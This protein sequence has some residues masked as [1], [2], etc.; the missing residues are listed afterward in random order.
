MNTFQHAHIHTH[1]IFFSPNPNQHQLHQYGGE[2]VAMPT[3]KVFGAAAEP[4]RRAPLGNVGNLV[5]PA[6]AGKKE[7]AEEKPVGGDG[8]EFE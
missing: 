7:D 8:S 1:I 5:K 6:T 2:N 3:G 4:A